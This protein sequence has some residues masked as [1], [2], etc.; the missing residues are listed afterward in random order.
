MKIL[1]TGSNGQLGNEIRVL[2]EEYPGFDFIY[3]DID[4]LD[5]TDPLK[6][7]A[8][9]KSN[10]PRAV[11]NCAA[12]T[13]VDKA[14]SDETKA[15]LI[16]AAA[17][18]NLSRSAAKTGAL[19]VHISTDYVFDG[20]AHLPYN[21]TDATS[22]QSAYGRTKLAGEEA[23][24]QFATKGIIF[25]TSWLYSAFGNNF[26][27]TMIKY[28]KERDELKVVFDQVG[29]PT[30]ARDLAKAILDIIP[31]ALQKQGT[32]LFHYSNE[33]VASWYDFAQTVMAV[34][35]INCEIKPI[36][37]REYPLPAQRP[38]FSVLNKS[39]IKETYKIRIPYWSDSVKH[40]IHRL[41]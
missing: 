14:E 8:F 6:V 28:G 24:L 4:E 5:I 2:A 31:L 25:R 36:L 11:I 41:E 7:D 18:E 22:P 16:N 21:E 19:I 17:V 30:Y 38:C 26:V 33:G 13:S 1:I 3:T 12:Y 32:E 20:I 23:V 40:C 29:T 10:Q 35:G 37:T 34:C 9:F 39:K 27:K 15:H